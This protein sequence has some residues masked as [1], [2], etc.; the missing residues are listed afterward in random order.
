[1]AMYTQYFASY[2]MVCT[3]L[4]ACYNGVRSYFTG[5]LKSGEVKEADVRA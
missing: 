4:K 1:M 5:R 2:G 3:E